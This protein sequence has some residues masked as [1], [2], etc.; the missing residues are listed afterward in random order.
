M[1]QILVRNTLKVFGYT[2][3]T[4]DFEQFGSTAISA[5]NYSKNIPTI[6][7]LTAWSTGWRAALI[8]GKAP[9]LQDMNAAMFVHSFMQG[10]IFQEGIPEW[11]S[12]TTYDAG[13]IVKSVY[14][15][16]P[17]N[18]TIYMS[19]ADAN[20]NNA[21]PG[22]LSNASWQQLLG[23]AN[24]G[25]I[26]PGATAGTTPATGT[27]GEYIV[28]K[29]QSQV[30]PATGTFGNIGQ[31]TVPAGVWSVTGQL[32]YIANTATIQPGPFELVVSL[33]PNTTT[34]DHVAGD[35]LLATNLNVGA[36]TN[37]SITVS[38]WPVYCSGN[39]NIYIK[40]ASTFSGGSPLFSGR[41]SARRVG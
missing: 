31:I 6:Q 14:T 17:G 25:I 41:I 22:G 5:T 2:G 24:G 1:A 9:V 13:S 29:F 38:D 21:L 18:V 34:T 12:G 10:Y 19:L 8:A 7:G 37:Q 39:T 11:D 30:S 4:D 40:A 36:F 20:L 27:I 16:T 28:S 32:Y 35:N 15:G 23:F 3:T 33:Y 26:L